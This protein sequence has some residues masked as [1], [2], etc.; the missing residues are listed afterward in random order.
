LRLGPEES[1]VRA[2]RFFGGG[3]SIVS[4]LLLSGDFPPRR[5]FFIEP[6]RLERA[7]PRKIRND[8]V[9][10]NQSKGLAVPRSVPSIG[11]VN[12]L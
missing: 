5:L 12:H 10:H 1:F 6:Q 2:S 4:F 3:A 7:F 8:E 9:R 11:A